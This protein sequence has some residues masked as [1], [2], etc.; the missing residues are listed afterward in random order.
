MTALFDN[1]RMQL[2]TDLDAVHPE[3]S[4]ELSCQEY[5]GPLIVRRSLTIEGHG[6]TLW[7]LKGP[8]LTIEAGAKVQLKNLRIEVT[9]EDMQMSPEEEVAI[10]VAPSGHVDLDDVE[11]RGAIYGLPQEA[12]T[13]R[14]PKTL[15][16]GPM[17]PK[18]GRAH[19]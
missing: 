9:G 12:G 8:V 10:R 15:Y 1:M 5:P 18:I 4:L 11:V 7:A 14:Y 2:Q 6:A 17:S 13:W 19:V 16:L 3:G